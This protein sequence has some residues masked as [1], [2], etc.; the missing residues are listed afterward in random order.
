M[1][2]SDAF[3]ERFGEGCGLRLED[4]AQH[5]GIEIR[6]I[7]AET[8][9]GALL[10]IRG[11]SRAMIVL[12]RA[13]SEPG[14]RRFTLAHEIGHFVLPD[15]QELTS[16]CGP[17]VIGSWAGLAP[18]ERDAN[19]FAADILIPR[20]LFLGISGKRPTLTLAKDIAARFGTSLTAAACRLAE[21]TPERVAV[22]MSRA[23]ASKWYRP[24]NDFS[25]KVRLAALD[26]GT[27]AYGL[28]LGNDGATQG[29]VPADAWLFAENLRSDA[30]IWEESIPLPAYD[31]VL[32][33]IRIDEVIEKKT[34]Y[35]DDDEAPLDPTEFTLKRARWR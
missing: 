28:F 23:G 9:D 24:S 7:R 14:R 5:L 20:R 19:R 3:L 18:A 12:N 31:S 26:D 22:V 8:F 11:T 10:R 17:T 30:K 16:P 6:E 21:L 13:I 35:G 32:S 4:V 34:A 15:Q 27:L 29:E 2:F 1:T 33:L 25:Q